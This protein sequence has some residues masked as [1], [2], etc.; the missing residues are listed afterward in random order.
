MPA[1]H[2]GPISTFEA[3]VSLVITRLIDRDPELLRYAAKHRLTPGAHCELLG[4][5]PFGGPFL[6][7]LEEQHISIA[8]EAAA[9]IFAARA[10]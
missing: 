8:P 10:I 3:P 1:V 7:V 9:Q 5:E 4:R 6:L 2:E